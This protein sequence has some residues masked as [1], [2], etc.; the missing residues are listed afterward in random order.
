VGATLHR[1]ADR[2]AGE[3]VVA[4]THAGFVMASILVLFDIRRPGTGARLDPAHTS[5]TEWEVAGGIWRLVR[6]NDAGHLR[7]G[8]AGKLHL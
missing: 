6:Y 4:V 3:T 5:L 1:L 8:L 7:A 2:F